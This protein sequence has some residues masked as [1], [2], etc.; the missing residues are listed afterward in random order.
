MRV[1]KSISNRMVLR[2][3]IV[4]KDVWRFANKLKM[5]KIHELSAPERQG[6]VREVA[7]AWEANPGKLWYAADYLSATRFI[8]IEGD[9]YGLSI[10]DDYEQYRQNIEFLMR[11]LG[12][13]TLD[14]LVAFAVEELYPW[15]LD[16]LVDE[17]KSRNV[18][19]DPRSLAQAVIRLGVGAPN[20]YNDEVFH[21]IADAMHSADAWG[22]KAA[23]WATT[24]SRWPQFL[25]LLREVA[26]TDADQ[27]LRRQARAMVDFDDKS[28]NES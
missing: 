1:L 10:H 4:E 19:G 14:K 11:V 6:I 20:E 27:E 8:V 23:I 22:R 5:T 7:W 2:K 26:D 17:V 16:E 15:T 3:E 28:E 12:P 18:A 13:W 9:D 24:Y 21:R 25:P